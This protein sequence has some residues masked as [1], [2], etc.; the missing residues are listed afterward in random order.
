MKRSLISIFIL[1]YYFMGSHAQIQITSDKPLNTFAKFPKQESKG[2]S[3]IKCVYQHIAI[4]PYLNNEQRTERTMEVLLLNDT[5]SLIRSYGWYQIDSVINQKGRNRVKYSEAFQLS[6]KYKPGK[7]GGIYRASNIVKEFGTMFGTHY[8]YTEHEPQINWQ[9]HDS[10]KTICGHKCKKAST[11]YRGRHWEA[12]YAVDFP[13]KYGP[14]KFNGLPGLILELYSLDGEHRYEAQY[15]VSSSEHILVDII[16]EVLT[17]RETYFKT[18][19]N[20]KTNSTEYF[21]QFTSSTMQY[22]RMFF[23][24]IEKYFDFIQKDTK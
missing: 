20:Y 6:A 18:L 24:P 23:N 17:N 8:Y 1:L 2:M 3:Q 16:R 10:Y 12:W 21:E 19:M 5:C 11:N 7:T 14:Y 22:R 4:D 9:Q 13:F 15:V